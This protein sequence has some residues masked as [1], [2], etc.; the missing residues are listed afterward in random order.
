MEDDEIDVVT[1]VDPDGNEE[2][3]VTGGKPGIDVGEG[4]R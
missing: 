1:E 4:F 3:E 2:G